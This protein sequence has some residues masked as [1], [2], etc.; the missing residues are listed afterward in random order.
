MISCLPGHAS[1]LREEA[2]RLNNNEGRDDG[3]PEHVNLGASAGAVLGR[4]IHRLIEKYDHLRVTTQA[5]WSAE[6]LA[7]MLADGRLDFAIVGVC[8]DSPPP[9]QPGLSWHSLT[10]DPVFV[11][12]PDS[13][14]LAS[15]AEI[16]LAEL[17]GADWAAT[18]GDG[19]FTDCFVTAC[20]RAGFTPG[21]MY[22]ADAA[23]C[24]DLVEAGNA[25]ALCH[26]TRALPGL[27]TVPITDTP[28]RW[29]Q[30]IGWHPDAPGAAFSDE[31]VSLTASACSDLI[32]RSP[33]YSA[34][35]E[36]NPGFGVQPLPWITHLV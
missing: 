3:R 4:L 36:K 24:I 18:P 17:S 13:H 1:G 20:A 28:L 9:V 10:S 26:A 23:S 35:L 12:L 15:R 34:W 30:L 27:V 6:R 29:R 7:G 33:V 5:S 2:A 32:D 21:A 11:L 19:C 8:A 22:E 31:I 25:V 14:E 16:D